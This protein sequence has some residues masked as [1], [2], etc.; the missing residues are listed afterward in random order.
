[1]SFDSKLVR[2]KAQD[3]LQSVFGSGAFRFQTGSIKSTYLPFVVMPRP[4]FRFQTG[5][6]KSVPTGSGFTV[7]LT[8]FRFQ[9]GSI[10]SVQSAT[11]QGETNEF[12]FQT[13]SIKSA[14]GPNNRWILEVFRFQTGSIKRLKEWGLS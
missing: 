3:L 10:K 6:I 9:T 1:M 2:L 5:S 8:T 11:F 12:R 14:A 13:G 4:T 7:V